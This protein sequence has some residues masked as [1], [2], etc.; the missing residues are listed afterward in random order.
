MR[1]LECQLSVPQ[2]EP[3][4]IVVVA[5]MLRTGEQLA[6]VNN[7]IRKTHDFGLPPK[8]PCGAVAAAGRAPPPGWAGSR[9]VLRLREDRCGGGYGWG[10]PMVHFQISDLV[11]ESGQRWKQAT[12]QPE[13]IPQ[14]SSPQGC[15]I[16]GHPRTDD[17]SGV[18]GPLQ[19]SKWALYTATPK[20][21][22][23]MFPYL[24]LLRNRQTLRRQRSSVY[25]ISRILT[26][27]CCPR[28]KRK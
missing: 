24:F 9:L 22:T 11:L 15:S 4:H 13:Q 8:A 19:R 7:E 28:S 17:G 27:L 3:T 5:G 14:G 20:D 25:T 6:L 16:H 12:A 2:T 21:F 26:T 23:R 1:S 18:G 10:F